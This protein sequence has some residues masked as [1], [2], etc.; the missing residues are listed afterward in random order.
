[1]ALSTVEECFYRGSMKSTKRSKGAAAVSKNCDALLDR[2]GSQ[3]LFIFLLV[4]AMSMLVMSTRYFQGE[5]VGVMKRKSV[6][7]EA[8]YILAVQ[9]HI[10][11]GLGAIFAGPFQ[12]V[13]SIRQRSRVVHRWIGYSYVACVVASGSLSLVAAQF[14]M[15]GSVTRVGFSVLAAFWLYTIVKAVGA[16][17]LGE[18]RKHERYMYINYG[19]TFA[20]IT[21]RTLLLT[22]LLFGLDFMTV[23]RLS[24]WLPW[25]F[26]T[27]V[28]VFLFRRRGLGAPIDAAIADA[29]PESTS[30]RLG[31]ARANTGEQSRIAF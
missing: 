15:G 12:F 28:A 8:W 4:G 22:V 9:G 25:M 2:I 16:I 5:V 26:N 21:Q 3:A 10:A 20:A 24:A 30:R 7:Q 29:D 1:M 31:L 14:A 6:T 18:V 19:L 13:K 17:R 27:C 11:L 23:Y